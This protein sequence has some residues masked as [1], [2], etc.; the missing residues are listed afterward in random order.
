MNTAIAG[1][2]VVIFQIVPQIVGQFFNF[3]QISGKCVGPILTTCCYKG[4]MF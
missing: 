2:L 3:Q 1:L 4:V